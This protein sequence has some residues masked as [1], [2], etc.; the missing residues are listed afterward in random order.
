LVKVRRILAPIDT[1]EYYVAV[2]AI[3]HMYVGPGLL[4]LIRCAHYGGRVLACCLRQH[5]HC[6]C[7]NPLTF[8]KL[9]FSWLAFST[10]SNL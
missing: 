8:S 5:A 6:V 4:V 2:Y 10:L 3:G 9:A 7:L 1:K